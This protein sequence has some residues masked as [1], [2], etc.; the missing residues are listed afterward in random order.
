MH[1]LKIHK[2]TG[3]EPQSAAIAAKF[4]N[5][6]EKI[7]ERAYDLFCR[8]ENG[9]SAL[10]DWLAAE[11][12]FIAIPEAELIDAKDKFE[13]RMAVPGFEAGQIE[14]TA[15]PGEI[16][17]SAESLHRHEGNGEAVLF[18]EFGRRAFLRRFEMPGPVDLDKVAARLQDGILT[19]SA[20]KAAPKEK[21]QLAAA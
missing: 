20:K 16:A 10:E 15:S 11:R 17:V 8:R 14:I 19:I 7:R 9:G 4:E 21:A 3:V 2:S 13:I 18:S 5:L 12:E 6:A 1:Q